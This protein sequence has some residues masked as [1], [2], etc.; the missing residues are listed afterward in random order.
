MGHF[1]RAGFHVRG[2]LHV[3]TFPIWNYIDFR[4]GPYPALH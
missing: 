3:N 1:G 2:G 4:K